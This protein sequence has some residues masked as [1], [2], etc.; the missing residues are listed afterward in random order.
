MPGPGTGSAQGNGVVSEREG[1]PDPGTVTRFRGVRR[2]SK[3]SISG[4]FLGEKMVSIK[5]PV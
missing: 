5:R 2:V 4:K 3:G 1:D